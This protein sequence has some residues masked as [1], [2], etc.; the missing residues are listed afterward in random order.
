MTSRLYY[1]QCGVF[2]SVSLVWL[3][4]D[5]SPPPGV[6]FFFVRFTPMLVYD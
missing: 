3:G 6:G 1:A 2:R 4:G 5:T